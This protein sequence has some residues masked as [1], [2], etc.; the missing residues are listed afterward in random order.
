M[1]SPDLKFDI[2]LAILKVFFY[3]NFFFTLFHSLLLASNSMSDSNR[4]NF[5]IALIQHPNQVIKT[6]K[7]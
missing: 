2:S 4:A 1:C 6:I 3:Y 5:M 7:I